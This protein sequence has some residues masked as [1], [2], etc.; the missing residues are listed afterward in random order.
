MKIRRGK[1]ESK[2]L[3]PLPESTDLGMGGDY[4]SRPETLLSMEVSEAEIE[5]EAPG[6]PGA[7]RLFVYATDDGNRSATA[8]I[9]FFI[10][11]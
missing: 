4:E 7:Y 10:E 9:P 6:N 11:E 8:N 5:L 1:K 2:S 3:V